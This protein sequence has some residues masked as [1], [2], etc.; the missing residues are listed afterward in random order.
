MQLRLHKRSR[1]LFVPISVADPIGT[2]DRSSLA[3][4][5]R[6]CQGRPRHENSQ[7]F[8]SRARTI[9]PWTL[10]LS[11]GGRVP[12]LSGKK[13]D[14][15]GGRRRRSS[16]LREQTESGGRFPCVFESSGSRMQ[17]F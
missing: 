2:N 17:R 13:F 4:A 1:W 16:D 6:S 14:R 7:V 3:V 12:I 8:G 10:R 15:L 11:F 5:E 9:R